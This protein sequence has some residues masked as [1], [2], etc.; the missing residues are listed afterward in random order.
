M[1]ILDFLSG[2]KHEGGTPPGAEEYRM[3]GAVDQNQ[4]EVVTSPEDAIDANVGTSAQPAEAPFSSPDASQEPVAPQVGTPADEAS[5]E[6]AL[7]AAEALK[8]TEALGGEDFKIVE[9]NA[10]PESVIAPVDSNEVVEGVEFIADPGENV[11][12]E[13]SAE[14]ADD[15]VKDAA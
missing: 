8:K 11:V 14:A 6:Q 3:P 12:G 15:E 10:T 7:E 2:N 1:G 4:Q 13:S 5:I 9:S